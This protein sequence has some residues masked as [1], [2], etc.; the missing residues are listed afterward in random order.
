MTV[1]VLEDGSY[2]KEE[3]R[4]NEQI[5]SQTFQDLKLTSVVILQED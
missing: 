4:E 1:L 2:K 3:F 5:V